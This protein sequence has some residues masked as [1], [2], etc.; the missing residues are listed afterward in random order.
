MDK[1]AK[2]TLYDQLGGESAISAVVDAFYVKVMEDPLVNGFFKN[3]D[4][5]KQRQHQTNFMMFAFG[6]PK[7]YSGR[8]LRES[9]KNMGLKEDHFNAIVNHLSSTLK[10]FKV[11]DDLIDQVVTVVG[12]TKDDILNK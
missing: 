1:E 7:K 8:T 10:D 6:G 11:S 3:T 12:T 2:K 9:H 5:K 4:M